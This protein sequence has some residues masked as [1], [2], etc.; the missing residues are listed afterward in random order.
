MT[1]FWNEIKRRKL[2]LI[3][4][5]LGLTAM[6]VL[7]I[8]L[9]PLMEEQMAAFEDMAQQMGSLGPAMGMDNTLFSSYLG[10]Y[11]AECEGIMAMGGMIYAAYLGG[12][13]ISKEFKRKTGEFL[14]SHPITRGKVLRDK[15]LSCMFM[16]FLM[17]LVFCG[18]GIAVSLALGESFSLE[19]LLLVH[20]ALFIMQLEVLCITFGFSAALRNCGAGVGIAIGFCLYCLDMISA[21]VEQAEF[22][23][24]ITPFG[25]AHSSSII[26]DEGVD[27]LLIGLG[28]VYSAAALLLSGML[29]RK[30]ELAE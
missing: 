3:F 22:L 11:G 29:F 12:T 10:Y 8:V 1:I 5:T 23:K 25:Y 6:L 14:F 27:M 2:P 24:Y 7:C 26:S 13:A 28:I 18:T 20:L 16:L 17:N 4:L 9:Y 19:L 15:L 30:R 21:L